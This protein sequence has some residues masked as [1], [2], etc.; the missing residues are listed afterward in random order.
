VRNGFSGLGRQIIGRK[1]AGVTAVVAIAAVALFYP[2]FSPVAAAQGSNKLTVFVGP[3]V[4]DDAIWMADDKGLYKAEGLDVELRSFPS[5]STALESFKA[6]H[7]DIVASGE[8]PSVRYW[9]SSGKDYRVMFIL[10][11]E[12]E[13]E[14]GM[15]RKEI[16]KPTDL[17][18]KVV[19]TRVGSTGSWFLSEY[20]RKNGVDASKVEIKNLSTQVLPTALCGGDISAFFIWQPFGTRTMEICPD[21]VYQLTTAKGYM[22]AYLVAGAR[23]QWLDDPANRDKIVRFMRSTLKGKAIAEKEFASVA[24]Y[25]DKKFGM[26][27]Q[28]A[29]NVWDVLE[30]PFA[31]DRDFYTDYCQLTRWMG[32]NDMLEEDFGFDEFVWLDGVREVAPDMVVPPPDAC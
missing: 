16:T 28:A 19:A 23:A 32:D 7:G 29:R 14:V 26:S 11:R 24:A 30:R 13:G 2:F 27:E 8:L 6:G 18:G 17:E 4:Y 21:D 9:A 5:G 15:A 12:S 1:Y 10:S 20:L 31:F 3:V 25:V 22:H